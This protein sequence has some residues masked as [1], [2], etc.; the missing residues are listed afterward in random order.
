RTAIVAGTAPPSRTAASTAR[1]VS[2]LRGKGIPWVTMVD[3]SAT[4]GLPAASAAAA[5][6][7][8][9]ICIIGTSRGLVAR[10]IG[11]GGPER[12]LQGGLR[13]GAAKLG[14]DMGGHEGVARAGDAADHHLGRA[15]AAAGLG[16]R[17]GGDAAA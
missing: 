8:R 15:G 11:G 5:S 13:I 14:G 9:V 6:G 3:S 7:E 4:S 1:A 12:S 10:N 2:T 16:R 17:L